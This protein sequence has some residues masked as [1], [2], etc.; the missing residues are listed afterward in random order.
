MKISGA[1]RVN[2][3]YRSVKGL[4]FLF[5]LGLKKYNKTNHN[6]TLFTVNMCVLFFLH[7]AFI[8]STEVL[9]I[10]LIFTTFS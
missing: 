6:L 8:H 7:H 10:L 3:S 4:I 9:S 5:F 1:R 2:M